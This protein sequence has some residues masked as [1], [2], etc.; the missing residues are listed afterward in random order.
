MQAFTLK[1]V[2]ETAIHAEELG[3]KFYSEMAKKFADNE[4]LK[5][6][7]EL[8]AKDEVEHKKQFQELAEENTQL[9]FNLTEEDTLY[10]KGC[11]V[12]KFF[13]S[14]KETNEKLTPERI[15]K[16]AFEFEKESVLFYTGIR[17]LIP[18]SDKL[19]LIIKTEK[20]HMTKL[21]K[22]IISDSEFR[23]IEDNF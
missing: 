5:N 6:I 2:I 16:N 12:S 15:L 9:P 10:F 14:M 8:L 7:F 20:N 4:K 18:M 21:I 17:Y 23:G 19:D 11:D 22:Y 13:P 1:Q 3:I